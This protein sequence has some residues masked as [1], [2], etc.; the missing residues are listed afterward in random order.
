MK[1]RASTSPCSIRAL[2]GS[3]RCSAATRRLR[4][5]GL[6]PSVAALNTNKKVIYY[7]PLTGTI[8]DY[9]HGTA[10][11][12]NIA[13]YLGFAPGADKLPGTAD[14]IRLHGVAPQARLMGYKVCAAVG[15]CLT[16]A[17]NLAIEDAVSPRTLDLA[18][19]AG[20]AC[21]QS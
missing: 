19:E 2:I 5:T 16:A 15:S 1:V 13:G 4:V 10:A 3:M 9:G 6:A 8:D 7:L 20:R 21:H 11:A 12:S 14:D 18:A 17:T